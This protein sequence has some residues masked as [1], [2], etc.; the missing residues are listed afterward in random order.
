MIEPS[1]T[2]GMAF[3]IASAVSLV[4]VMLY[5]ARRSMPAVRSLGPSR[6]YLQLHLWGGGLFFILLLLHTDGRLPTAGLTVALW[7]SSV[8]VVATGAVGLVLQR[9]LPTLMQTTSVEVN[10][11]RIPELIAEL[12]GR[13]E[14]LVHGV[15][16][17]LRAL[18]D[19]HIAPDMA[20]PKTMTMLLR[21]ERSRRTQRGA[22]DMLKRTL[23]PAGVTTLDALL[24]L[25]T[26]KHH[27]DMHYAL[28][29]LLRGWLYVH[30]P[31]AIV[32]LGLVALHVFFIMYF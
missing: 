13:A 22:M 5:S 12:R 1:S 31:V 32:L 18:Y 16:G 26:T 30:L 10:L 24:A 27:I 21:H 19:E 28:Q 8:W 7:V 6:W 11:A 4:V 20:A 3:G 25:Q 23:S 14:L 9:T 29:R 15:D 17:R 2:I